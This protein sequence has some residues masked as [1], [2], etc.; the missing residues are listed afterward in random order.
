M[1]LLEAVVETIGPSGTLAMPSWGINDDTVFEAESTPV[2]ADL[3]VVAQTFLHMPGV[4]RNNHP[5]AFA[6]R[7]PLAET[8]LAD[9]L[10]LPPHSPKSPV[11]RVH[12]ANGM[13]LLLG[14]NHDANTTLHLAELLANVPYGI[15]KHCTVAKG[16]KPTRIDYLE[17]DHCCQNFTL[18]D[19]WLRAKGWQREGRVANGHARL[20]AARQVTEVAQAQLRID[21]LVFLHDAASDCDECQAARQSIRS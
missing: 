17:N 1:G 3:G 4:V 18:A 7:G 6:A 11:G 14:V 8:I 20:V 12:E 2:A 13:V 16:G 5:F 10:P 9:P 21:P 15:P 19:D